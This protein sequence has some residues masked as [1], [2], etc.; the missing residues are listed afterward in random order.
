MVYKKGFPPWG[1]RPDLFPATVPPRIPF[2][3]SF[4]ITPVGLSAYQKHSNLDVSITTIRHGSTRTSR[5]FHQ[6]PT[7]KFLINL[8]H[9]R[10]WTPAWQPLT[11]TK[12]PTEHSCRSAAVFGN[13][14]FIAAFR[15]HPTADHCGKIL[16]SS[17]S[18]PSH[19]T[20]LFLIA[21]QGLP[22]PH[23]WK[24]A[25]HFEESFQLET[26]PLQSYQIC[27]NQAVPSVTTPK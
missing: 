23:H 19:H 16:N 26:P 25:L 13:S 6:V 15:S 3:P 12:V 10:I 5:S 20:H 22:P 1:K 11:H 9:H 17:G 27:T 8:T 2:W 21:C 14:C 7:A 4:P 18:S 24:P